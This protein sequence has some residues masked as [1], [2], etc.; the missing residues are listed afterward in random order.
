M[1]G[2]KTWTGR[3]NLCI[4]FGNFGSQS[5]HYSWRDRWRTSKALLEGIKLAVSICH[6]DQMIA[7]CCTIN[8]KFVRYSFLFRYNFC[9]L[10]STKRIF[11]FV[12]FLPVLHANILP[13]ISFCW[14]FRCGSWGFSLIFLWLLMR[15]VIVVCYIAATQICSIYYFVHLIVDLLFPLLWYPKERLIP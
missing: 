8:S 11:M 14:L 13:L 5:L 10:K 7:F 4:Q 6:G 12:W 1:H 9:P 3:W 15:L 2:H